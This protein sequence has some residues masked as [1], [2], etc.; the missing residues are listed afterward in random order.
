MAYRKTQKP[1]SIFRDARINYNHW[2]RWDFGGQFL[3]SAFNTNGHL[4]FKN[5]W[6][7][8][9]GFT[10]NPIE[11][12]NNALRGGSSLRRPPGLGTFLYV[13]SDQRKKVFFGAESFFARG[14]G[15]T[16]RVDNYS[17]YAGIQPINAMQINLAPSYNR[18]WR[19]PWL[20]R[21][22]DGSQQRWRLHHHPRATAIWRVVDRSVFVERKIA[23]INGA[24]SDDPRLSTAGHHAST[25]TAV[26]DLRQQRNNRNVHRRLRPRGV[27]A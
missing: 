5:N 12:S 24:H 17:I 13:N 20:F 1:F 16:V 14:F 21:N 4:W 18:S 26:D 19:K 11:I 22:R 6:R 10:F 15:N 7:I 2:G 23:R 9:S 25:E 3:Y 27:L 8:G